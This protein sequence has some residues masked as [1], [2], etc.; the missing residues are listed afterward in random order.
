MKRKQQ[1]LLPQYICVC[2]WI[3]LLFQLKLELLVDLLAT[4]VHLPSNFCPLLG[5]RTSAIYVSFGLQG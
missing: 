1:L 5:L 3:L 2:L 4:A